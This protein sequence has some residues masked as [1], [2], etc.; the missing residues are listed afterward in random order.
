ME[1]VGCRGFPTHL[2]VLHIGNITA[3]LHAGA[4]HTGWLGLQL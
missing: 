1:R 3:L 4:F 2:R